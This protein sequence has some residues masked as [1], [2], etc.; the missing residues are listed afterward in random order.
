[1][2][3]TKRRRE[4]LNGGTDRFVRSVITRARRSL[5]EKL[6]CRIIDMAL[7]SAA[8]AVELAAQQ[9][10]GETPVPVEVPKALTLEE[11]AKEVKLTD[12][13]LDVLL[14]ALGF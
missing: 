4:C 13:Y 6:F 10:G 5:F 2:R 8:S 11:I 7:S 9:G 14:G 12:E 1:M 3:G